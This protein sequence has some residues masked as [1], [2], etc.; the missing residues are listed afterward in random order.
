MSEN[1]RGFP[2]PFGPTPSGCEGWEEM[3]PHHAL[4]GEDRRGFEEQRFWFQDRLHWPEPLRPFDAVMVEDIFTGFSQAS[5]RLF[6]VPPSL[7]AEFRIL[8]GYVYMS[9][10]AVDDEQVLARRAGLFRARAGY[11]YENWGELYGR[12]VEKV[13]AAIRDLAELEVPDLP[14]VEEESVITDALGAGSAHA[15][16]A[17]YSRLLE[18]ADRVMQYH[19]EFLNLGYAAY[20]VLYEFCRGA[21]PD[22][23]DQTIAKMLS[24]A[25]VLILRPDE[26]LRRLAHLALE[27]GVG[28]AVKQAGSEQELHAVLSS[29]EAGGRWLSQFQEAKDPWFYFSCGNGLNSGHRSW[30]DDTALPIAMIG[31]YIERLEAGEEISRPRDA[32][33]AERETVTAEFREL[34][35]EAAREEFDQSLAL[36][37][38]VFGYVEDHN[39]YIEHWHNTIFWN[40]VREFGALLARHEFIKAAEDV[41][42][43]RPDEVGQA[44]DELRA[45][46]SAGS[47][48]AVRG[49]QFWPPK[50]EQ[51][52]SI[53][54]AMR[55]WHVPPALG[56]VPAGPGDPVIAMLWGI[57]SDRI[58]GWLRAGDGDSEATLAGVA[59][60]AG[61]V[62]GLARVL[63]RSDQLGELQRDEILVAA[64]TSPSWTP[65]F[66][67][68]SGAVLDIGGIM[69]HAAI[70]AREYGLPAVLGTGIGTD[71][72]KTGDRVRVD[73]DAGLVTILGK[74]EIDPEAGIEV[75]TTPINSD[76]L[77]ATRTGTDQLGSS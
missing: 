48:G 63:L 50:V 5:S 14:E 60:S 65:A 69:S 3:Y 20:A 59:G 21:F 39:F 44:L 41:F 28:A 31:L 23:S 17:A 9:G 25:D 56:Q 26:E 58:Q 6:A 40:K 24:G 27:L 45:W 32:V 51:R 72:I 53:L 49:P 75:N 35:S 71:E 8:N 2:S 33:L 73:G 74:K 34:L 12:W 16:L 62:E 55:R 11:Y 70:V 22:I 64:T 61:V 13:E 36:A 46:W 52:K 4:F 42:Y 15:L 77:K 29:T 47:V 76:Q 67:S 57:S 7:G 10:N 66:A 1:S 38:M 43:L 30:I 54:G 68:I 18:G 19:F 37:R